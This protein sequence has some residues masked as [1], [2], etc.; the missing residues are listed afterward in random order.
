MTVNESDVVFNAAK[1][2]THDGEDSALI[3][4]GEGVIELSNLSSDLVDWI[5]DSISGSSA[6]SSAGSVVVESGSGSVALPDLTFTTGFLESGESETGSLPWATAALIR[7]M[8]IEHSE[9]TLCDLTFYHT[10]AYTDQVREFK[11]IDSTHQFLWEGV[12]AHTDSNGSG[13]VHYRVQNTGDSDS[14]FTV[15]IKSAT[16]V[17]NENSEYVPIQTIFHP[18]TSEYVITSEDVGKVIKCHSDNDQVTI[19]RDSDATIQAGSRV[20]IIRYGSGSLTVQPADGSVT[21]R[22][23]DG[24]RDLRAQYSTASVLKLAAN[25]WILSGDLA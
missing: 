2:H 21:L 22:S 17:S 25:L 19:P 5:L 3:V 15:T 14:S 18:S 24:D 8:Y 12:W 20:D 23:A 9:D 13:R 1:G 6:G 16:M 4:I 11:V 7:S 10:D